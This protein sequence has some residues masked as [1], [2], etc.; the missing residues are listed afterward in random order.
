[1]T[2]IIVTEEQYR[3]KGTQNKSHI[4]QPP[5]LLS[6]SHL[7]A[8]YSHGRVRIRVKDSVLV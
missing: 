6:L 1:M 2:P 4:I 5:A 3:K 7:E 8:V